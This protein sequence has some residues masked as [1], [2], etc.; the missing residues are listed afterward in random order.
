M[1][2]TPQ[3][4]AKRGQGH[5]SQI[6]SSCFPTLPSAPFR[7]V[8]TQK[9]AQFMAPGPAGLPPQGAAVQAGPPGP[10][11]MPQS[12]MAVLLPDRFLGLL[13]PL[14]G[15]PLECPLEPLLEPLLDHRWG[16]EA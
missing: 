5:C 2:L 14:L 7:P 10:P 3:E 11:G 12:P 4:S 1:R 8:T 16:L 13:E 6:R 15:L 9:L